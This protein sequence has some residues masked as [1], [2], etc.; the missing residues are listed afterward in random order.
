MPEATGG[1]RFI[2][3]D[4]IA[5]VRAVAGHRDYWLAEANADDLSTPEA[6]MKALAEAMQMPGTPH[7]MG[8]MIDALGDLNWLERDGYLL[9]V[10]EMSVVSPGMQVLLEAWIAAAAEWRDD[11]K[12]FHM[13]ITCTES[14]ER[15]SAGDTRSEPKATREQQEYE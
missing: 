14:L 1:L 12:P 3:K 11:R 2:R 8:S 10:H 4:Q 7:S 9:L 15:R 13:V 6:A 5:L